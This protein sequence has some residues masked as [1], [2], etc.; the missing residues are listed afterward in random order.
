MKK[1][2]LR[3]SVALILTISTFSAVWSQQPPPPPPAGHGQS[4]D[5]DP[6]QSAPVGSGMLLLI[7]LAGVYG[8]KKTF[9]AN[10]EDK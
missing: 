7:G 8:I 1:I 10:K 9:E 2:I 4:T 3:I 5:Q 6:S